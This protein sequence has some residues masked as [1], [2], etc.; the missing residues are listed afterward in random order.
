[1]RDV[2]PHQGEESLNQI[3]EIIEAHLVSLPEH[4]AVERL[5]A[6]DKVHAAAGAKPAIAPIP[7]KGQ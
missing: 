2:H 4:E 1:M 3:V 5:K 6:I 7:P